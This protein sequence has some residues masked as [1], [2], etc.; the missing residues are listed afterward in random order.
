MFI[1][2]RSTKRRKTQTVLFLACSQRVRSLLGESWL[3]QRHVRLHFRFRAVKQRKF[4][5][6]EQSPLDNSHKWATFRRQGQGDN[7]ALIPFALDFISQAQLQ[8][9]RRAGRQAGY[10]KLCQAGGETL[11]HSACLLCRERVLCSVFRADLCAN[12]PAAFSRKCQTHSKDKLS[13]F[14]G[15]FAGAGSSG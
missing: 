12:N 9:G 15:Q 4:A 1:F 14:F 2:S 10:I 3:A 13:C 7:N 5:G 11:S 8:A 6:T